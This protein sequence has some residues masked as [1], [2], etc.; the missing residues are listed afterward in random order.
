MNKDN[1]EKARR[2][3]ALA[4]GLL[5]EAEALEARLNGCDMGPGS[6]HLALSDAQH[7]HETAA[8]LY[9]A[10]SEHAGSAAYRAHAA[11]RRAR[12]WG[13]T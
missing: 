12:A 3:D 9:R 8:K 2:H 13:N 4:R 7:A 5:E 1:E 10:G 11:T 6:L